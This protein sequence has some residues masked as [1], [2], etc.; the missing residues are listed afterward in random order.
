MSSLKK[1]CIVVFATLLPVVAAQARP[2]WGDQPWFSQGPGNSSYLDV[3]YTPSAN[4]HIDDPVLGP[5]SDTATGYGARGQFMVAPNLAI[6]GDYQRND[7]DKLDD[8]VDRYSA[9]IGLVGEGGGIYAE[10]AGFDFPG[11]HLSGLGVHA[12]INFP[13]ARNVNL[14]GDAGYLTGLRDDRGDTYNGPDLGGGLSI[15]LTPQLSLFGEYRYTRLDG[16]DSV[17]Y[18]FDDVRTGMRFN[19]W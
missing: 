14:F 13:L 5:A 1:N 11:D 19:F 16:P 15:G 8:N 10:Y 6:S 3:Y 9:G 2:G 17:S 12:R 4:L 7:Y 18:E